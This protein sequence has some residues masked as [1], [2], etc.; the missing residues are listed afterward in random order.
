MINGAL[1]FNIG[2][3]RDGQSNQSNIKGQSTIEDYIQIFKLKRN[4]QQS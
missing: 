2:P 3:I 4:D 1:S